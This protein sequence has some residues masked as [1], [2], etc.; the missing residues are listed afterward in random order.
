MCLISPTEPSLPYQI[1]EFSK[2]VGFVR[3]TISFLKSI[4]GYF[5]MSTD[6]ENESVFAGSGLRSHAVSVK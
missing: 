4:C 5:E 1:S 2:C 6:V 3:S